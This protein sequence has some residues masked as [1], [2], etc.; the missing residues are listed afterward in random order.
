MRTFALSF[1]Q[2][3]LR[4]ILL[5]VMLVAVAQGADPGVKDIKAKEAVAL[6]KERPEIIVVDVRTSA[7]YAQGHLEK[8]RNLDFFGGGFDMDVAALPKDSAVLL[9]CR[10]G[11]RSAAAAE[12]FRQAGFKEVLD[13]TD[14]LEGWKK[15]GLPLGKA[16]DK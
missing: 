8:A 12:V 11:R 13:M 7:E 4:A 1:A 5:V 10:S 16:A 14:G 15:A 6:L 3:A 2:C 9:Y